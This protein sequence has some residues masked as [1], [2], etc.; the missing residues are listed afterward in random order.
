MENVFLYYNFTEFFK[1]ESGVFSGNQIC[2]SQLNEEHFMVFEKKAE[3]YNL[4][5]SKYNSKKDVG[6][7][8]PEI[9]ELLIENYNKSIPD[10]RVLLRKYLE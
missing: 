9:L 6:M 1:D 7:N 5:V 3:N 2:L 10:H 8:K 4:Y